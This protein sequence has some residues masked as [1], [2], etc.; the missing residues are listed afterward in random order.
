MKEN[1]NSLANELGFSITSNEK[2]NEKMYNFQGD[3]EAYVNELN[4]SL[5]FYNSFNNI[6]FNNN[7]NNSSSN[8]NININSSNNK[9]ND[10]KNNIQ[11]FLTEGKKINKEDDKL[12]IEKGNNDNQIKDVNDSV[13]LSNSLIKNSNP[14]EIKTISSSSEAIPQDNFSSITQDNSNSY[15]PPVLKREQL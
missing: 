3:D 6:T 8:K 15:P 9:G 10:N 14:E 4:T 7:N 11:D 13:T 1:G 2:E 5:S 12:T